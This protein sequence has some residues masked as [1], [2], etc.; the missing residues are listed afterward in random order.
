MSTCC[1]ITVGGKLFVCTSNGVDESHVNIPAPN[2][3]SFIAMD[4][5]TGGVLWTDNSPGVNILHGQWAS[6]TYGVFGGQPQIIFPGGDGWLYSFDPAGDGQGNSQLLWKF[7]MNPKEALYSVRG[8]STRNHMIGFACSY[9][10]L[11]YF[12]VGEDPEHGEGNGH[13]WCIDPAH[14]MD[15]SDVSAELAVDAAGNQ[16]P[17][18]R[19]QA[20][21]VDAGERAIPNPDSAVIWHHTGG[22]INGNGE[23]EY[24]EEM[25]RTLGTP[26]IKDD[27][28][29]VVDFSGIVH[30]I[31]AKTGQPWWSYDMFSQ[32][33]GS[34]L[35]VDD[36][37]YV[38]NEE[39]GVPCIRAFTRRRRRDA[40]WLAAGRKQHVEFGLRHADRRQ[41]RLVHDE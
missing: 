10:G 4:R 19:L 27:L 35:V 29:Y 22:D 36:K 33:W 8:R 7:D 6:P 16:L 25:H 32:S 20:V 17:Q 23:L 38:G 31:D 9:D 12:A 39:G 26:A 41:Q 2:A 18:R 1:I 30:C 34:A 21:D 14:K 24:E 13:L 37:I 40:E 11:L 5:E 3:P 28:L 15:G